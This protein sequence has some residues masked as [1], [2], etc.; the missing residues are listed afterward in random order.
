[1]NHSCKFGNNCRNIHPEICKAW[2]EY[3]Q[4]RNSRCRLAIPKR[5]RI[6]DDQGECHKANCWYIHPTKK[7]TRD[8]RTYQRTIKQHQNQGFRNNQDRVNFLENWPKPAEASMNINQTLA[9]LIGAMEKVNARVENI[10]RN[11]INRW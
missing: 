2:S 6:Y 4:C 9:R 3:G 8:Q 10:E 7:S 5:C 1:M 11:Q